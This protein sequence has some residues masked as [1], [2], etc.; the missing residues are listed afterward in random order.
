M[1]SS[2]DRFTD[3][4]YED[5]KKFQDELNDHGYKFPETRIRFEPVTRLYEIWVKGKGQD[6][7]LKFRGEDLATEL[8]D[9]AD[10]VYNNIV[11]G[12]VTGD[13]DIYDY[14]DENP[15]YEVGGDEE[16]TLTVTPEL[17]EADIPF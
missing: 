11:H 17:T 15:V 14:D 5:S 3:E 6:Y 10:S 7:Y 13:Y 4:I 8:K 12:C 1:R 16:T 9:Y 2:R